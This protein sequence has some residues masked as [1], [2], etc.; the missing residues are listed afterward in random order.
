MT[1]R[2]DKEWERIVYDILEAMGQDICHVNIPRLWDNYNDI[3]I[4]EDWMSK[5][6]FSVYIST[7]LILLGFPKSDNLKND[8]LSEHAVHKLMR[9]TTEERTLAAWQVLCLEKEGDDENS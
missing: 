4:V 3:R 6:D 2:T 8:R 7:L 5:D 9:A 1:K